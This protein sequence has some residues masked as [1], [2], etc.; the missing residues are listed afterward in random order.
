[1]A[2][3]ETDILIVGAGMAGAATAYHLAESS[4]LRVTIVDMEETPGQHSSGR[5]VAF[6][7]EY[8]EDPALRP[9]SASGCEVLRGGRLAE[10]RRCGA[11]LV[12]LG[13]DDV[14]ARFPLARGRGK[15]CPEDGTVDAAGLLQRYLAGRDL[16]LNN[17][18]V[19][20][21]HDGDRLRV[22]TQANGPNATAAAV[23]L[24]ITCRILVNAAG[25]WAGVLAGLPLTPHNRHVFVT[26]PM[27]SI[28]PSWPFIWDVAHGLYFR[29][30]S[31]GLLL[32]PCDETPALPGAY[33]ED[34]AMLEDL[35]EKVTRFQPALS[36]LSIASGWVGQRT[37]AP[38]RRYVIG[39]DPRDAR[40]FHV[41]G[42]GG[43]G[44]TAS[45]SVGRLA[46]DLLL[47]RPMPTW[48]EAF[49]PRRLSGVPTP[50][51]GTARSE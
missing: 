6:I 13:D 23:D 14:A 43:H 44:V 9:L 51:C 10:Y 3:L 11:I 31:G 46:A 25:P 32:S 26:R 49:S 39:F 34:P 12:G 21:S 41:A 18:V 42:L 37:F 22:L 40:L 35:C 33:H 19:S 2:Q 29:P 30:E 27:Q 38:D 36:D 1:M 24:I 50:A 48:S 4:D 8:E 7:R 17:R 15:W 20:W 16:R 5:N 47:G 45:W 28:D